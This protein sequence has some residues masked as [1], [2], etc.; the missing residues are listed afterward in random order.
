V[1]L[2]PPLALALVLLGN[3][4]AVETK[5]VQVAPAVK[6]GA[7]VPQR[8]PGQARAVVLF[9]GFRPHPISDA[10]ALHAE[11]S[12]WEEPTSPL[13]K[14]LG[15]DADVFAFGYA[16]HE[17]VEAVAR[18]A[19]LRRHVEA[20]RR[21]G[22]AEVV[23]IGYSAGALVARYFVEDQ[24][25]CGVT[26]V[27][28]VCPPNGGTGW[29]KFTAGVRQS[30]EPFLAS[31]SKESRR[32]AMRDRAEKRIPDGVEFV[33]VIGAFGRAG[34][35]LVRYDCQWTADLQRQGVPAVLL[36]TPHVTAMRS[37][38]VAAKLAEL[39]RE[40]QPRWAPAQVEAGRAKVFGREAMTP[41]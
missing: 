2:T 22:Y 16:Q 7:A 15:R 28:Q 35:G 38:A 4:P 18:A 10:N 24:G 6:A 33:C 26:K 25:P 31:L 27:I 37:K 1:P 13:V 39:V 12:G 5:F 19:A 29:G 9:H 41:P 20:L 30:Q 34:D 8:T 40:S 21:A 36:H 32:A 3:E 11:L 14:A 17:P 23:L